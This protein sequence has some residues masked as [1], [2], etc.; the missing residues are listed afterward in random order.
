MKCCKCGEKATRIF[1]DEP[2]CKKHH[3]ALPRSRCKAKNEN[4]SRCGSSVVG[5]YELCVNHRSQP[6]AEAFEWVKCEVCGHQ[7][8][9]GEDEECPMKRRRAGH[10]PY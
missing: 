2:Y 5:G 8:P 9:A 6:H 10:T 3:L 4:G 1:E 7:K